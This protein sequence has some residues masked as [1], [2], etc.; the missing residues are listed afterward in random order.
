MQCAWIAQFCRAPCSS[1]SLRCEVRGGSPD[2]V[3]LAGGRS[4][5]C[6]KLGHFENQFPD[7]FRWCT[8]HVSHWYSHREMA[9]CVGHGGK[10][11]GKLGMH[12]EWVRIH[13]LLNC[14]VDSALSRC[15]LTPKRCDWHAV[16]GLSGIA[17]R[18]VCQRFTRVSRVASCTLCHTLQKSPNTQSTSA[19]QGATVNG[20]IQGQACPACPCL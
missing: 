5:G 2:T 8:A 14:W 17:W 7:A 16:G 20:R 11:S 13:S 19:D 15:L 4:Q 3:Q 12:R 9:T 10:V 18:S 6:F 1:S